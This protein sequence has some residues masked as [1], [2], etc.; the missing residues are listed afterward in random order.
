MDV[1]FALLV[2]PAKS[3]EGFYFEAKWRHDG[4]QVKRRVGPAWVK[5]RSTPLHGAEGWQ[6]NYVARTGRRDEGSLTAREAERRVRALIDAHGA[7]HSIK[8]RH[9]VVTFADAA[10]Q[11]LVERGR[12]NDWKATTRRDYG[13][14][15]AASGQAR[16]PRGAAPR[17]RIMTVFGH[18]PVS[19]IDADHV[20]RF[21]NALEMSPRSANKQRQVLH[22]VFKYAVM[23]GWRPDNPVQAV[24]SFRKAAEAELVV[25]SPEQ[26]AVISRATDD[27]TIAAMIIA[28]AATGLRQGELLALRWRHVRFAEQAI[29]VVTSYSG[30]LEE[31]SPKGRRRRSVPMA[32]AAAAELARLGQRRYFTGPDDLV[33]CATGGFIDPATVRARYGRALDRARK[34]D[35][36]IPRARFHDLRHTFGTVCA[37]EGCDVVSIMRWLGHADLKTTEIYMHYAP[38]TE[39]AARLSTFFAGLERASSATPTPRRISSGGAAPS[40]SIRDDRR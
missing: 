4:A 24:S 30:G 15:L 1:P 17:A 14:M 29:D 39:Q 20:R 3:G 37:R 6:R 32:D 2:V 34:D 9:G 22:A 18:R 40:A 7:E 23:R 21:L 27:S 19:K 10:A 35:P 11:F 5:R 28:A 16:K 25:C 33:F 12:T 36:T 8:T 26:V 13:E 31:T 38:K